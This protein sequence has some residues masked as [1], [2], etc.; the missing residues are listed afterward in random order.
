MKVPVFNK[1]TYTKNNGLKTWWEVW[2]LF[3]KVISTSGKLQ[4]FYIGN[5]N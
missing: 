1:H 5:I 2:E 4:A 3:N